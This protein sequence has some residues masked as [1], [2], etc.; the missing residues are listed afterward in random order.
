MSQE[1]QGEQE[2]P[3]RFYN[4]ANGCKKGEQCNFLH[5]E[6]EPQDQTPC[7]F[8]STKNGC[9]KGDACLFQHS[10]AFAQPKPADPSTVPCRFGAK[11]KRGAT[12]YFQHP[13]S[14]V[15]VT[16]QDNSLKH[17]PCKFVKSCNKGKAC[18]YNHTQKCKYSDGCKVNNCTYGHYMTQPN[19]P[20]QS[21]GVCVRDNCYLDH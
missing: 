12:C 4:T 18:P 1:E 20:C 13:E 14:N 8:F 11:C 15:G 10:A 6:K 5:L 21:T 7:R 2:K 16:E 3:C 17:I 9:S 19:T